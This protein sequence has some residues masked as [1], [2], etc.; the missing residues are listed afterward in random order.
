M[1]LDMRTRKKICRKIFKRYQRAG[2]K[3]KGR[4]LDEYVPLLEYNRDYLA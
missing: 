3:D 2:K 4:L 1:G